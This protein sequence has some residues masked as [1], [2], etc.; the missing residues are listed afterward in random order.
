[1][2]QVVLPKKNNPAM[3]GGFGLNLGALPKKA[4]YQDEFMA[5]VDE[6][7]ESWRMQLRKEKRF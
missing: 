7:S 2:P 4:D 6:F 3:P 5:K 1:M